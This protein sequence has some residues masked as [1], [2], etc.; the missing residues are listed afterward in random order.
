MITDDVHTKHTSEEGSRQVYPLLKLSS[1]P[2]THLRLSDVC[3]Y[4]KGQ[5]YLI[6]SEAD[7]VLSEA[8]LTLI[9]D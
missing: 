4:N 3:E 1:K 5:V 9:E 7:L 2:V 8:D 6:L